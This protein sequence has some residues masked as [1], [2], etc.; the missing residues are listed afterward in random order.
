MFFLKKR[1]KARVSILYNVIS[2]HILKWGNR[3]DE[4][5]QSQE[6]HKDIFYADNIFIKLNDIY[7]KKKQVTYE[8]DVPDKNTS[9]DE[10]NFTSYKELS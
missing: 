9:R 7:L 5:R 8:Y 6:D 2:K 4:G 3:A 10:K 1:G